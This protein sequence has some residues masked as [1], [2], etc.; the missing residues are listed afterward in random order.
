M[1]SYERLLEVALE[2]HDPGSAAWSRQY[3]AV[4]L[5]QD[6]A[7]ERAARAALAAWSERSGRAAR[8]AVEPAGP[9]FVAEDY[10]QKHLVQRRPELVAAFRRVYPRFDD[11]VASTAAA[12]VNG[13][14]GGH[15]GRAEVETEFAALG[16]SRPGA[17]GAASTAFGN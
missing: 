10:H 3:R 11:F 15:L 16:L 14:L 8:T 7:Q 6:A 17:G 4:V 2:S 5:A 12:R 1:I 9:F 13:H